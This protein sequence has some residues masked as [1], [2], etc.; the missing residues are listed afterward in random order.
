MRAKSFSLKRTLKT[1]CTQKKHFFTLFLLC[2]R[3]ILVIISI[4][5]NIFLVDY[6]IFQ[7]LMNSRRSIVAQRQKKPVQTQP[8]SRLPRLDPKLVPKL[9]DEV[10]FYA[11]I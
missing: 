6:S 4:E 11:V 1:L 8:A 10:I 3:S 9:P 5:T 2:K 7:H